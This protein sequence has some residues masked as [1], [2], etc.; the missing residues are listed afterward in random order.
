MV[1]STLSS[2]CLIASKRVSPGD[3]WLDISTQDLERML[4]EQSGGAQGLGLPKAIQEG[5]QGKGQ[6]QEP[7]GEEAG[8]SLV[9][10]TQ[11]MKSFLSAMS[12]HEGAELP[13]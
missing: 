11:G 12:S 9:A 3:S 6:R 8:Y 13:W 5:D 1:S 7:E 10:V 2:P 4:Q